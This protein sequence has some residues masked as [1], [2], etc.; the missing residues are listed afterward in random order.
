[1]NQLT[2]NPLPLFIT[3]AAVLMAGLVYL[4]I[5]TLKQRKIMKP[6]KLTDIWPHFT[7]IK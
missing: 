2:Q 1:M 5:Q 3:L 4:L 7:N 6:K